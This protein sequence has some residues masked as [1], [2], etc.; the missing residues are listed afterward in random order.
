MNRN[1]TFMSSSKQA[2][3]VLTQPSARQKTKTHICALILWSTLVYVLI[4]T[5]PLWYYVSGMNV[6]WDFVILN[7]AWAG[8]FHL[9]WV[10]PQNYHIFHDYH[11]ESGKKRKSQTDTYAMLDS[12][13]LLVVIWI[14]GTGMWFALLRTGAVF[15]ANYKSGTAWLL[16][17]GMAISFLCATFRYVRTMLMAAPL[18]LT[19]VWVG[20]TSSSV[21]TASSSSDNQSD[22][23][24]S[25]SSNKLAYTIGATSAVAV[26][27]GVVLLYVVAK[28]VL[29]ATVHKM[30]KAYITLSAAYVFAIVPLSFWAS[31]DRWDST[32]VYAK[33]MD[34]LQ[35][36]ALMAAFIFIKVWQYHGFNNSIDV[37]REDAHASLC[38]ICIQSAFFCCRTR[39]DSS[40]PESQPLTDD[41]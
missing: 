12:A 28:G 3:R 24:A 15:F 14:V 25:S 39:R 27:V 1:A 5:V 33:G 26:L 7:T 17:G 41:Q 35:V 18:L 16:F 23:S 11:D 38:S 8:A 19:L 22:T 6:T 37:C 21:K 2:E 31:T 34:Y 10:A 30:S 4:T 29:K 13:L 20:F 40:D 9:L 36:Y 32:F